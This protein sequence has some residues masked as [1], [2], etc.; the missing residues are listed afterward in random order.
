MKTVFI[1]SDIEVA[2]FAS[3]SIRLRWPDSPPAVYGTTD[4][5]LVTVRNQ[6]PDVVLLQDC[7]DDLPVAESVRNIREF[8]DVPLLVLGADPDVLQVVSAL[9]SGADDYV[10]LPCPMTELM[11]RVWAVL[12]RAGFRGFG[13]EPR[14]LVKG[15][16]LIDQATYQ[17][18]LGERRLNLTLTEF[19]LLQV[20]ARN[21]GQVVP[22]RKLE[23]ALWGDRRDGRGL[24]KKYVQ[25]LR[26]KLEDKGRESP[27]IVTIRG[28]GYRFSGPS[29]SH[30]PQLDA[31]R[32]SW[33]EQLA[34][35]E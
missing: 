30:E 9:E 10:R 17:A 20:L 3:T 24:V 5:G 12:R 7:T 32:E 33:R 16:L 35:A 34:S 11:G 4:L 22:H 28:L 1:G 23:E 18:F 25:R 13:E 8:S 6:L 14:P 31:A 29:T 21:C 19:R 26:D 2:Q 15:E 27:W